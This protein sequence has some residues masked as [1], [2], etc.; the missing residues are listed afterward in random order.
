MKHK[1]PRGTDSGRAVGTG[2]DML[3][4]D[5]TDESTLEKASAALYGRRE[6]IL[7]K[8][9]KGDFWIA[10]GLYLTM[11]SVAFVIL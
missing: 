8:I 2:A 11:A 7:T 3:M 6:R 9:T 4:S 10:I 5:D 1:K